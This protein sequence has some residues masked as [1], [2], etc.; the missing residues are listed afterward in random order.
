MVA[1]LV[2]AVAVVSVTGPWLLDHCFHR[3]RR[4]CCVHVLVLATEALVPDAVAV[5]ASAA[6]AARASSCCYKYL[7]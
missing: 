1:A 4:R 7:E 5:V 3:H 6:A 2:V